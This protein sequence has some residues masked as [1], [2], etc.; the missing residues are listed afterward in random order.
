MSNTSLGFGIG[1]VKVGDLLYSTIFCPSS[2]EEKGGALKPKGPVLSTCSQFSAMVL[3][4]CA[5]PVSVLT[6]IPTRLPPFSF[7]FQTLRVISF[8]VNHGQKDGG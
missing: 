1:W 7:T 6:N 8:R 5:C 4:R 3:M 2:G